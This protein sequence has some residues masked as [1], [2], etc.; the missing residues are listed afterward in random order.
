MAL[1]TWWSRASPRT[2][3]ASARLWPTYSKANHKLGVNYFS[4]PDV[5]LKETL[6]PTGTVTSNNAQVLLRNRFRIAAL[7][8]ESSTAC[9]VGNEYEATSFEEKEEEQVLYIYSS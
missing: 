5:V 6:T 4:N 9:A 3:W 7:G 2:A 8:D 1:A